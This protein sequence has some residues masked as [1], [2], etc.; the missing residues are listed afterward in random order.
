MNRPTIDPT[1]LRVIRSYRLDPDTAKAIEEMAKDEGLSQGRLLDRIIKE[2]E[3]NMSKRESPKGYI[4]QAERAA[5]V[6]EQEGGICSHERFAEITENEPIWGPLWWVASVR[7]LSEKDRFRHLWRMSA[8]EAVR[9]GLLRF[10]S[11][12]YMAVL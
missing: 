9:L 3:K 12:V 5:E 8:S 7:T 1:D 11:G 10:E 6:V 4:A 2:C